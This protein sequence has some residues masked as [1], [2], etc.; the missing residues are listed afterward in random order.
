M[1]TG[2]TEQ[3]GVGGNSRVLIAPRA[4]R[5]EGRVGEEQGTRAGW[6]RLE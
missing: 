4:T 3:K 2:L 6:P 1:A 5:R